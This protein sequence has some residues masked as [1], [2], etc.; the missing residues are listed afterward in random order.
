MLWKLSSSTR[1][2]ST[3][4]PQGCVLSPLLFSLYTNDCTSKDPSVK[5]LK[6]SDDTTLISLIQDGDESAYRQEVLRSWLSGAVL[7]TWSL[8]LYGM[9][10]YFG[11]KKYVTIFFGS[12]GVPDNISIIKC[13]PPPPWTKYW[14]VASGQ[15]CA[16]RVLKQQG[17]LYK[18]NKENM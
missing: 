18:W 15:Q 11:G 12:L 14:F 10:F 9:T 17:F 5:L 1:T 6:F 13:V 7:T 2:I 4:A 16:T 3:G 8:S